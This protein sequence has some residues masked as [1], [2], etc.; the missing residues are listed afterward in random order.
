DYLVTDC[1]VVNTFTYKHHHRCSEICVINFTRFAIVK[2]Q[3]LL[4]LPRSRCLRSSPLVS[5][6]ASSW[7]TAVRAWTHFYTLVPLLS[8]RQAFVCAREHPCVPILCLVCL[9]MRARVAFVCVGGGGI[10]FWFVLLRR[11]EVDVK[12]PA[13]L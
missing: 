1:I 12:Q 8:T 4:P 5:K 10:S 9:S 3:L 11:N 13:W 2:Q 6:N 7:T